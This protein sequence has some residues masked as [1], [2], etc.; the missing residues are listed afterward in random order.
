MW[1]GRGLQQ[2]SDFKHRVMFLFTVPGAGGPGAPELGEEP[3]V[4]GGPAGLRGQ[5]PLPPGGQPV[6]GLLLVLRQPAGHVGRRRHSDLHTEA[7][8]R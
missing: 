8:V 4:P 2:V 6:A 1:R 3:P 7:P 5:G